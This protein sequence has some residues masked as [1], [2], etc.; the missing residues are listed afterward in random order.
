M[1][2]ANLNRHAKVVA[3]LGP[4]SSTVE[5]ICNLI[6]AG[7]NV[8][9]VN[10]SHGTR[11]GHAKLIAN[12]RKASSLVGLEVAVLLDLQGPKVRVDKVP[13]DLALRK[14]ETWV[15]GR[16]EVQQDYPEYKDCF[17]PTTYEHL[18]DDIEGGARILFN[19]G[20]CLEYKDIY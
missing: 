20:F 19:D 8:A 3:T 10:M 5:I 11:E 1:R 9:R 4:A 15:I 17:I 7:M 12:V 6:L 2:R 14:G 16:T 13:G 18:V